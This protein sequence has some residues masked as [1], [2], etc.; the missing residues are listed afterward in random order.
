LFDGDT[1]VG[2]RPFWWSKDAGFYDIGDLIAGGLPAAGWEA[3]HTF[4]FDYAP[5]IG[6]LPGG[7][8]ALLLGF[9][10]MTQPAGRSPFLLSAIPEPSLLSML[11]VPPLLRRRPR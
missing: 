6:T 5:P 1:T 8:P 10:Q 4:Y 7:S 3:L 9:G 11:L 2:D